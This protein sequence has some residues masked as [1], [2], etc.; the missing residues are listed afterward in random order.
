MSEK[1]LPEVGSRWRCVEPVGLMAPGTEVEVLL[2]DQVG[3][4]L[5]R[6]ERREWSRTASD[7]LNGSFVPADAPAPEP[8]AAKWVPKVGERALVPG[9][10]TNVDGEVVAFKAEGERTG[11]WLT[12]DCSRALRPEAAPAAP[13]GTW[14]ENPN[15]FDACVRATG[16]VSPEEHAAVKAE[17]EKLRRRSVDHGD[18]HLAMV[19]GD[20]R[21]DK[22]R[23]AQTLGEAHARQASLTRELAAARKERDELARKWRRREGL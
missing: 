9:V 3:D 15:E 11:D 14:R 10:V 23:M 1:T 2:I 6:C 5:M 18:Y 4:V 17:L 13:G 16:W 19:T 8:A 12:L 7:F 20:L 22:A 21:A